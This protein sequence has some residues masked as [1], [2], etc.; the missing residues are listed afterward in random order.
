MDDDSIVFQLKSL[1]SILPSLEARALKTGG[2]SPTK[3]NSSPLASPSTP[4]PS[5]SELDVRALR[6]LYDPKASSFPST[7]LGEFS[8]EAFSKRIQ[9]LVADDRALIERLIRFAQSHDLLK[10]NAERAQRLAR[11]SSQA[12]E[13]YQKQVKALQDRNDNLD[14]L[15]T[16]LSVILR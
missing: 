11:D 15:Q 2:R 7:P 16:S 5:L 9:A 1:W 6:A 4:G 10:T 13:T 14:S 12:L 8:V 3:A